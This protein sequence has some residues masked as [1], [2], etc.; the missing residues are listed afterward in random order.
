METFVGTDIK[1]VLIENDMKN[2][3]AEKKLQTNFFKKWCMNCKRCGAV[4][5]IYENGG[6]SCFKC[7]DIAC[8]AQRRVNGMALRS[9]MIRLYGKSVNAMRTCYA[10]KIGHESVGKCSEAGI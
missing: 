9:D 2:A 4:K 3:D 6:C 10:T 5:E 7:D 8:P 1:D